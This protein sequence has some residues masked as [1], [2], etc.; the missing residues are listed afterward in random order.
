MR[1]SDRGGIK[2]EASCGGVME[3][4]SWIISRVRNHG[5]VGGGIKD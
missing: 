1:R 5:G 4:E 3:E 2:D